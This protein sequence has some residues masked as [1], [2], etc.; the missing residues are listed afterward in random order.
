[1][2]GNHNKRKR[3]SRRQV[4]TKVRNAMA[5]GDHDRAEITAVTG[6]ERFGCWG[7]SADI[8]RVRWK[9]KNVKAPFTTWRS[10]AEN[11]IFGLRGSERYA[12]RLGLIPLRGGL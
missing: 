9:L 6:P 3:E 10:E 1:M 2:S 4:R 12:A 5:R 7:C 8:S 11:W